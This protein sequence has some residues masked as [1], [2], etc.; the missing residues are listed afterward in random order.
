ME[1]YFVPGIAPAPKWCTF[2][3]NITEELEEAKNYSVYEDYKFLT[4]D[5]LEQLGATNLIGTRFVKPYLHGYFIDWKL[6]KKLKSLS[7]PFAYDKYL[8]DRKIEKMN[9]LFGDRIVMNRHKKAKVNSKFIENEED[10]QEVIK[11]KRFEKMFLDKNFEIDFNSEKFKKNEKKRDDAEEHNDLHDLEENE[12]TK[13]KNTSEKIV[14]P[15]LIKLKE[16]LLSK[17]RQKID[18]FYGSKEED[19]EK[20][21]SNR[22]K[23]EDNDNDDEF[24]L[25]DK[26]S[27]IQVI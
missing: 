6:Y 24:D 7:D 26:I 10:N 23:D 9:K 18:K 12:N 5:D 21:M 13:S 2:L 17:K 20:S 14:N 16:K 19:L 4:P 27:K 11:D 8:E 1:M 25:Q 3:E 15:E 22:L